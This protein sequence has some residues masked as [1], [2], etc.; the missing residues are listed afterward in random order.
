MTALPCSDEI[1][2]T[3]PFFSDRPTNSVN[4]SIHDIIAK[5]AERCTSTTTTVAKNALVSAPNSH[6]QCLARATMR[7]DSILFDYHGSNTN[8]TCDPV[9]GGRSPM[10]ESTLQINDMFG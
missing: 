3:F 5:V 7:A 10:F 6:S 2:A 8:W 4:T 1:T 9:M